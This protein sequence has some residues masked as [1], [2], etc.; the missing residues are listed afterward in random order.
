MNVL[1][2]CAYYLRRVLKRISDS[3]KI[4]DLLQNSKAC[5][6]DLEGRLHFLYPSGYDKVVLH[7]E[8]LAYSHQHAQTHRDEVALE[9]ITS[10]IL[11]WLGYGVTIHP[12]NAKIFVVDD[13]IETLKLVTTLLTKAGY[14]TDSALNGQLA[15]A[16]IP[17]LKPNLILLDVNLPDID[18]YQ[19]YQK[20]QESST[21]S[22]IPIVFLSGVDNIDNVQ[23]HT[24][25]RIGYLA[26]P[27]KP[28]NL[29]KCVNRYLEVFSPDQTLSNSALSHELSNRQQHAQRLICLSDDPISKDF[30]FYNG[31]SESAYFFRATLDGRYLRVSQAFAQRCGYDSAE[32]M[33]SSVTNV[34]HQVYQPPNHQEQWSVCLQ[35]P[36]RV[37]T[38]STTIK[39][40][41]DGVTMNVLEKVCLIQDSYSRP[42]FYQGYMIEK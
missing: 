24:Q 33:I 22:N 41:N 30:D 34:W 14:N 40:N 21:T 16:K 9:D 11:W 3:Q 20:L 32:D 19:V 15:L 25:N 6:H 29:L 1:P 4:P 31:D 35:N 38:L 17:S 39:T 8:Q 7:L 36:N 28:N 13:T 37:R 5:N 10:Q 27:F 23:T 12:E 42:L 2:S 18:G 26:K